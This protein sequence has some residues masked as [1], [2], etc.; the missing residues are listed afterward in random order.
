MAMPIAT[1]TAA[2]TGFS[3]SIALP[4]GRF[5]LLF[6]SSG[7]FSL[8]VQ[9]GYNADFGDLYYEDRTTKVVVNSASGPRAIQ[10]LGGIDYR[11]NVLSGSNVKMTAHRTMPDDL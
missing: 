9:V 7:A 1:K 5:V 4:P 10:I 6:S 3:E 2:G 11:M 8:E